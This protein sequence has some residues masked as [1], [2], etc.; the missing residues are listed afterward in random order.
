MIGRLLCAAAAAAML[1]GCPGL[2]PEN[3][4]VDDRLVPPGDPDYDRLERP[5]SPGECEHDGDCEISCIHGCVP[6]SEGP[7]TCPNPPPP[8]PARVQGARC[9]CV[10]TICAY[11]E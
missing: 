11:F 4:P 1:A 7:V 2:D 9:L 10:D 3:G 6:V 5:E 8:K